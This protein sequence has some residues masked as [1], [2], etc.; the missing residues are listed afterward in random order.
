MEGLNGCG[1][2]LILLYCRSPPNCISDFWVSTRSILFICA[3]YISPRDLLSTTFSI[4]DCTLCRRH[5]SV[6][7]LMYSFILFSFL[8]DSLLAYGVMT[9]LS[10][11][12]IMD[13]VVTSIMVD[14]WSP[15]PS[16]KDSCIIHVISNSGEWYTPSIG[17]PFPNTN[18]RGLDP[19]QLRCVASSK[20]KHWNSLGKVPVMM[21]SFMSMKM[22]IRSPC[23]NQRPTACNMSAWKRL[24]GLQLR[25]FA[26]M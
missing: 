26:Y 9:F 12:P 8:V 3:G 11:L 20:P 14:L 6:V 19:S 2:C 4:R 22:M 24:L 21:C 23:S 10:N 15:T 16:W 1:G 5:C 18:V 17:S 7:H 25:P 13:L